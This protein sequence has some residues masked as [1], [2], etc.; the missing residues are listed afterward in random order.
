M[1]K[2]IEKK[3]FKD[4][5]SK[6]NPI[7]FDIG[8]FDG[9]DCLEFLTVFDNPVIYAFE[10]DDRSINLFKKHVKDAPIILIETL[11]T[12]VD[13]FVDFYK[14]DSDTRRH[15]RYEFDETCW[16]SSSSIKKPK[17]HLNIFPDVDFFE[18]TKVTSQRLD[19]WIQDKDIELIDIMWVDINGGEAEFLE[20]ALDTI[21]TKVKYLYV[22]FNGV[23]EKRLYDN[24]FTKDD[25]KQTLPIFEEL[26][27]FNFMGNFGNV[28]LKNTKV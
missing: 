22:E 11:L 8:A 9:N 2:D 13:G 14:S 20:G 27:V 19:T 25:I 26:G 5:L 24:C 17:N 4:K 28:L 7:I 12:D 1:N 10:G 23:D 3:Y 21:N 6:N 15:G 16:S 18:A